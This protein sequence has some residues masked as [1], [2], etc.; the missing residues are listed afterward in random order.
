SRCLVP[1]WYSFSSAATVGSSIS[2][3]SD[4]HQRVDGRHVN[5]CERS[6]KMKSFVAWGPIHRPVTVLGWLIT[7]AAAGLIL[8]A[9]LAV[10]ARSHSASDTLY[11]VFPYW[12]VTF[13][14]W[15]WVARWLARGAAPPLR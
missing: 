1:C 10:D 5:E 3:A 8:N 9:F 4:L 11:G 2:V 7:L 6:S 15:D 13:L 12:G 14:L